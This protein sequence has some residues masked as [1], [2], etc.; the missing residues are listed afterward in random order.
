MTFVFLSCNQKKYCILIV[1][2]S[3]VVLAN[4]GQDGGA[5]C[6]KV[7]TWGHE[8]RSYMRKQTQESCGSSANW[9][10]EWKRRKRG[11]QSREA[12]ALRLWRIVWHA[13]RCHRGSYWSACLNLACV[14]M[15]RFAALMASV[16]VSH[17]RAGA[18]DELHGQKELYCRCS[19]IAS[20]R[21]LCAAHGLLTQRQPCFT[22]GLFGSG[23][24]D[25]CWYMTDPFTPWGADTYLID[26]PFK[27]KGKVQNSA[28]THASGYTIWWR[29]RCWTCFQCN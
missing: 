20:V 7:I 11:A 5:F 18:I 3:G 25:L 21:P 9:S 13:G 22:D 17:D 23:F 8:R 4:S 27:S 19:S 10:H 6:W 14:D 24:S 26:L 28:W 15:L 29:V 12:A 16:S 1:R 2:L